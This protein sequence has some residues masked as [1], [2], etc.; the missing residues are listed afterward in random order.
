V[1][2]PSTFLLQN[3][4]SNNRCEFYHQNCCLFFQENFS[5]E[6]FFPTFNVHTCSQHSIHVSFPLQPPTYRNSISLLCSISVH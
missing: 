6:S 5:Q 3:I 4:Y 1:A 2:V